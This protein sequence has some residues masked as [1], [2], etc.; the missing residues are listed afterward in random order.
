MALNL[1]QRFATP[2]IET[3]VYH[4]TELHEYECILV[5]DGVK[6]D[7]STYI[8]TDRKDAHRAARDML[9]VALKG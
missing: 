2:C 7:K 4:S 6:Q 8:T 3:F 1:I 9:D 5:I